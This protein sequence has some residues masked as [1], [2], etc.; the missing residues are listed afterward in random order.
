MQRPKVIFLDAVGTIIDVK[1]GVGKVYSDIAQQFGVT[2]SAETLNQSFRQS[3]KA[4]PPPRFLDADVQDIAQREFDWWRIVALNTFESAGVLKQFSDFSGFF[5]ELYI[6]FGTDEPWFV[7]PDVLLALVNWRRLGVELGVLSNFDSR[8]YSVLQSLGLR[9][10]FDSIT[11]S[12][13]VRAAKPDPQIFAVA[14]QKHN[15]S[16]DE[17]WHIGDSITEDYHGARAAGLRGIWINREKNS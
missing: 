8:L 4:A 17:A 1:G 14:L 15:C 7:Y 13:Q 9:D 3:F 10:Y 5:S 6:H 16:P 12:T 2:V 11:I